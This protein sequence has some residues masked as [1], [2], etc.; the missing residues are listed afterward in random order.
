MAV[1]LCV[2]LLSQ[3]EKEKG[4][5]KD[6][7]A[8]TIY[9]IEG[10]LIKLPREYKEINKKG[11]D[12][13][14]ASKEGE[15]AIIVFRENVSEIRKFYALTYSTSTLLNCNAYLFIE[16][17]REGFRKIIKARLEIFPNTKDIQITI[18]AKEL[19]KNY[20]KMMDILQTIRVE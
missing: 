20:N 13:A 6:D 17:Q 3:C 10:F 12:R 8:G 1:L 4:K 18:L 7:F 5:T 11:E 14:F 15:I 2:I 9:E 19:E 16:R